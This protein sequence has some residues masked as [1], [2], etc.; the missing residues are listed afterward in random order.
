MILQALI[1]LFPPDAKPVN[2][3]LAFAKNDGTIIFYNSSGP[4]HSVREDDHL[5]LRIAMGMLVDLKL[6]NTTELADALGCHNSTVG[7]NAKIL[8]EQGIKGFERKERSGPKG[9]HKLKGDLLK[10]AQELLDARTPKKTAARELGI[11]DTAIREAIK[12][13]DL[14]DP[15]KIKRSKSSEAELKAPRERAVEDT[16]SAAGIAVKRVE[17]RVLASR[18]KIEEASSTFVAA[19]GVENAG[20][21]LA[22][23][24][25]VETGAMSVGHKLFGRLKNGYYGLRLILLTLIFMALLRIKTVEQMRKHA[26]GDLGILLGLDRAPEVKTIRRKLKEIGKKGRARKF[27]MLLTRR[28]AEETP[29]R[30]EF[31]Y[32]DGH[33]RAYHG[34]KHKLPKT[35]V[36]RR[37]LCMPA[38]TDMWVNDTDSEPLL[39]VTAEANDGLLSMMKEQILPHVRS[40][41]GA[42]RR[43]TLVFDREGWSPK[44]FQQWYTQGFDVLTYRKGAYE[45]W[46]EDSFHEL[47]VMV[48]GKEK[49]YRLAQRSVCVLPA[50]TKGKNKRSAFWMREVRR[51]CDSGHQ[52]SV[53]TTRQNI[54]LDEVAVRMFARWSQENFFRYARHA[55]N[56]DHMPTYAV[57]SADPERLV[58]NPARK[59]M[60]KERKKAKQELSKLKEEY[61]Q[62]FLANEGGIQL[63]I[64]EFKTA[65]SEMGEK[66]R[67]QEEHI[68]EMKRLFKALPKR[69]PVK[70]LLDGEK[71]VVRLE[72][73]RKVIT[74]VLK[75]V[76][77]RAETAL[78]RKIEP[79]LKRHQ[80]DGRDFLETVFK[81]KA[82]IIP[83]EKKQRLVVRL[84]PLS[85]PRSNRALCALCDI[86]TQKRTR[87][88]GT[89]LR[90]VFKGP[91]LHE[92]K[93][94][95]QEV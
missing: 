30:M 66:I 43:V 7:R 78:L 67:Q 37:R 15:K 17:E 19:E 95:G 20:V 24:E 11:S 42:E 81:A 62:R 9:A 44:T 5:G 6:A 80:Q 73:E 59:E 40:L 88:P 92:N 38:T 4:I 21:L 13:G 33:V 8:S 54:G 75:M 47:K 76:G 16:E 85:N 63:T 48:A 61:A 14:R 69:V 74:D 29:E 89:D 3:K 41:A 2:D 71:Q 60:A 1:P 70:E 64:S 23:P 46:P 10:R 91:V 56:I 12:R 55:Y 45:A 84:Y 94:R 86:M 31:L 27:S 18:G 93:A 77:Y 28:W 52:T 83:D 49:S 32:V 35:H 65:E 57:E 25:I 34:R 36:A 22:L 72:Q 87:F 39:F 51:L 58:P 82:D 53:K 90:L 79:F 50:I 26:P 68:A